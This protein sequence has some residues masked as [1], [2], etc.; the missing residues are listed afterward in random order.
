MGTPARRWDAQLERALHRIFGLEA[1][2]P[3]QR[4]VIDRVIAG[5]DTLAIMPSGAGKSL[6]YQLP[7]LLLEGTTVVVSP[8]ISLM[9][10]Q[11]DKLREHGVTAAPVNST[12]S[13]GE[14]AQVLEAIAAG[15][16]QFVFTTP[17]RMGDAE[18]VAL[19]AG[20]KIDLVV[21]DEAHCISQWG[22]DF[23]PA[24]LHLAQA[25]HALGDPPVLALTATATPEVAGDI[26]TQLH[27]PAMQVLDT[28]L[29][30]PNLRYA[31]RQLTGE[32]DKREALLAILADT[33]GH[34]IVYT[35]T[36]K[37]AEA[38]H[39]FLRERGVDALLYHGKL[40]AHEREERQ[41]AFMA[42]R[43]RVMVA[44]NAF[45]MGIDKADVRFV[46]HYQVPGSVEAYYQESGRAGR[47]GA[48]AR[49]TLLYDHADRRI[50][51]Y[52]LG[53][54]RPDAAEL[55]AVHEG[56]VEGMP[57]PRVRLD[58]ALLEQA[59][60][61]AAAAG[62]AR[63]FEAI[64]DAHR[65]SREAEREKLER[66]TFY[67]HG[68]HCRWKML[69]EYFGEG[70]DFAACGLCD[71][72]RR[73]P[74]AAPARKPRR[75]LAVSLPPTT[76][77]RQGEPVEVPRYGKGIVQAAHDERV[78]VNFPNGDTREFLR[79]YVTRLSAGE[80]EESGGKRR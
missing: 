52:F 53:G 15:R 45:G 27:R 47:D 28:G 51:Q 19:L 76:D 39:A 65:A 22:H 70:E 60:V 77:L 40:A 80:E 67:A 31:V 44:T 37:A 5:R 23:R 55:R 68:A 43:A 24:F 8:L 50:Q 2:R 41:D 3:G 61:L 18:F 72:C 26:R 58:R 6:C 79:P 12:L 36:I 7:A 57:K 46:V 59:G 63:T 13:A 4:E 32:Q 38:L 42:G 64:A 20:D 48:P 35:A 74:K 10:D 25:L 14:E 66:M 17:E 54:H 29:Y 34:G 30:R 11:T 62:D 9:K 56:R 78:V 1:L 21:V 16:V 75:R 71:N 73:P 49:C 33:P 69:L